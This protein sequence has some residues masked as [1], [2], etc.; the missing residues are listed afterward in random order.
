MELLLCGDRAC[1]D[2]DSGLLS[3]PLCWSK[4]F[5]HT[6]KGDRVGCFVTS[7]VLIIP[8]C[9]KCLLQGLVGGC[10]SR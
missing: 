2:I 10:E 7:R 1:V 6:T 5:R 4:R 3:S 8:Y 9:L